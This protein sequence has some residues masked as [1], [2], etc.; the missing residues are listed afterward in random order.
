MRLAGF[1]LIVKMHMWLQQSY[2]SS[3]RQGF[4]SPRGDVVR[5]IMNNKNEAVRHTLC[6]EVRLDRRAKFGLLRISP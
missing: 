1:D 2:P 5:E 4:Q 6:D 3:L